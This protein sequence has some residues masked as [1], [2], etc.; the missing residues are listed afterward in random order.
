MGSFILHMR[1]VPSH[2][3]HTARFFGTASKVNYGTA[4]RSNLGDRA[5]TMLFATGAGLI[6]SVLYW[7]WK[8]VTTAASPTTFHS[9]E[10]AKTSSEIIKEKESSVP[11]AHLP[12]E[13]AVITFAPEVPPPVKRDHPVRLVVNMDST[14][15]RMQVAP[16]WKYDYWTFNGHTPGPFIRARQGDVLEVHYTNKDANAVGHNIDFHAVTGPGG[17]APVLYAEQ[18]ETKVGVFRLLQPGCFIYHCAAAP[19]PTHVANGMFGLLLVEPKDVRS[20]DLHKQMIVLSLTVTHP[21]G[22]S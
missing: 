5:L 6:G 11:A 20:Y 4:A 19:V 15:E 3:M 16:R 9:A 2:P 12:V 7:Q 1:R 21:P 14:V 17:G 18:N 22:S 8:E 13:Q 10:L